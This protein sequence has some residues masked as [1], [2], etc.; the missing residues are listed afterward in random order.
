MESGPWDLLF[1][2]ARIAASTSVKEGGR[3]RLWMVES[4]GSSLR[5]ED[6]MGFMHTG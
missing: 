6:F 1:V 4:L 3:S 2:S 5:T